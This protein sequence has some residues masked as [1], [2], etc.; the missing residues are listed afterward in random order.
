MDGSVGFL[1]RT[2]KRKA[3]S[4]GETWTGPMDVLGS[5]PS[6]EVHL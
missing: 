3:S 2:W 1:Q 5:L 4:E 6:S